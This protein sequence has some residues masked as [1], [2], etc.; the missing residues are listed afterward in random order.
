MWLV[1]TIL[2]SADT[3]YK[4][5]ERSF[6]LSVLPSLSAGF[7][8]YSHFHVPQGIKAPFQIGIVISVLVE[9]IHLLGGSSITGSG[10]NLEA[11]A[12]LLQPCRP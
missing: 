3:R 10:K 1:A 2:A 7:F 12:G 9:G 6:L 4:V 11:D 5:R 8:L